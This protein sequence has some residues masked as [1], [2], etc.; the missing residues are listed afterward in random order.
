MIVPEGKRL[1]LQ[2]IRYTGRQLLVLLAYDIAVVI[3]FRMGYLRSEAFEKLPLSLL[4]SA[5]G[6][7]VAFRNGASYGRWWEA[8]TLWGHIVNNTRSVGRLVTTVMHADSASEQMEVGETQRW[9]I[10]HL[11]GYVH[12][13]RQQLRGL[14]PWAELAPLLESDEIDQLR[15]QRNVALA[16]MQSMSRVIRSAADRG[17]LNPMEWLAIDQ[18]LDDLIDAQGGSERIKNTPMPRQYDYFLQLFVHM[19]CIVLPLSMVPSLGWF[20]PLGSSL[21]GFI[22]LALDRVGRDLE[23][24]FNNSFHDIPLTAI[25]RNIEINLRQQLGESQV[26][27]QLAPV[28]GVLW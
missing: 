6:V 14:E 3:L 20:T 26:P 1:L 25:T 11:I 2:L 19:Y 9:L 28:K 15:G 22:F 16:I 13:L 10:Y 5:I 8:R 12:S 27:T 23:D 24:P 4:G 21:V 18:N 7:I 17:W